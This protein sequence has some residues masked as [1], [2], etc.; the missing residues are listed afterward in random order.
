[1]T[2]TPSQVVARLPMLVGGLAFACVLATPAG[3]LFARL[4]QADEG[5]VGHYRSAIM[6][7]APVALGAIA[8]L[9][10][11]LPPGTRTL[12]RLATTVILSGSARMVVALIAGVAVFFLI[13]PDPLPYWVSL[14]AAALL[15]LAAEATWGVLSLRHA[16]GR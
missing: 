6:G 9:L 11:L 14:L 2:N 7:V 15:S 12:R 13:R 1:M 4:L 3:A 5:A 10:L 8:G 16:G